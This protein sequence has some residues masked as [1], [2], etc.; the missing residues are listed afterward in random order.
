[1][2]KL[3]LTHDGTFDMATGRSR[4]E[5]NWKNKNWLWSDLVTR[6][7]TTHRTAE[8]HTEYMTSKKPRQDE[9]KDIGG[10]VGGYLANARR[11]AQNVLHR[12]LV[13][14]DIDYDKGDFW[15]DVTFTYDGA[16]AVCYSTHK[17]SPE[18]PRYRLIMP[19]DREVNASEYEAIARKIAGNLN[20]E[21]FDPTTFQP[22]RLMYWPS[23]SKDGVY[24]FEYQD[25]EFL[26][27][28]DILA[29]YRDWTDTSEWPVSSKVDKIL[30]RNMQKQG[31]PLEKPGMVGIFCRGY[32]IEE[33]IDQYLGDVYET[34]DIE[35]RYTYKKGSTSGGMIVYDEKYAF[36]HH[37]TD[38]TSG[39]L[40]NAF[41]L[42]RLHKFGIRDEDAASDTPINKMPS[43]LAMV[44]FA[45]KDDKIK[46]QIGVERLDSARND[47][48]IGPE[49]LAGDE[50]TDSSAQTAA[51]EKQDNEWLKKLDVDKKGTYF[52]TIDNMYTVLANDWGLKD[53]IALNT[54]EQREIALKN[55]PWRTVTPQTRYLTDADDAGL[56]H[57]LEKVYELT[58][59][60]KVQDAVA[61]VM[62]KNSFHPVRDYLNSC[63]WDGKPRVDTLLIDY[64]GAED[65][66]YTR[67]VTRKALVASVA[68]VFQPGIK[69][70]YVLTIAGKQGLGKSQILNR[71]GGQWYSDS[72]SNIQGK[73][74]FESI[75]GVWIVEIGELAGLKKADADAVKH[76]VSKETDRY[77]VAYGRR[78]E[79]FPR[80]CTFFGTT[81][82]RDFLKDP[83]GGRRF[84]PV[85]TFNGTPTKNMWESLTPAE[86]SQVWAE[87]LHMYK[88]KEPLH[89]T[90][91]LEKVAE[92]IQKE[93]SEEDS[94]KGLIVRYLNTLL[95]GNW[96][97]M[98]IYQR[99]SFLKGQDELQAKGTVPR[100]KVC[101]AEIWCE[102]LDGYQKDMNSFNTK[103][104]HD[105]MKTI[106]GW[107][108]S[109][110]VKSRFELY[111]IQRSYEKVNVSTVATELPVNNN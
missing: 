75:Q 104:L 71:L 13:T 3:K 102:A 31:D 29:S 76:F 65:M 106:D 95:P 43:Y 25:G 34:C 10:Y 26:C 20:I 33:A 47:F 30:Q 9:I 36:S 48:A 8:T 72:F 89:L 80:Q 17:H 50:A 11:K 67:A 6:L 68:R 82:N 98:D 58:G 27:A 40:C 99:R 70:D 94:R 19:L 100:K 79:N 74:A 97:E 108:P 93:H 37:G 35:N 69:F 57:Y 84:W 39:K 14:L 63:K 45:S 24:F 73:E 110:G 60:Q 85:D 86:V 107:E 7:S 109:K 54:F 101:V 32:T 111:G 38:P 61:M 91:E 4:K 46:I 21:I 22:E 77:R 1:M 41:D 78:T 16:A 18:N 88:H 103:N 51:P 56:R 42:V 59:L 28:D 53:R 92:S 23:T 62:M 96:D 81:N 5:T 12:Q 64:L 55:L 87:A 105:I 52:S 49:E 15:N 83:T 2:S 66:P 90:P 44:E